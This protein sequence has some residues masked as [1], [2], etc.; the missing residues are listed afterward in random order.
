MLA[1]SYTQATSGKTRDHPEFGITR[2]GM[3]ARTG[4]VAIDPT[5]IGFYQELYVPGYGKGLTADTGG[6]IKGRRIDLCYDEWNLVLW[7]RW[8]DVYLVAPAPPASRINY[9][10]PNTPKERA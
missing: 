6:A 5:V 10:L 3:R 1:T 4:L 7:Y 8:V 9:R 2:T